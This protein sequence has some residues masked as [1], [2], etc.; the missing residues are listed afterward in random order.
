MWEKKSP[1]QRISNVLKDD[2]KQQETSN[3][4][5]QHTLDI[6]KVSVPCFVDDQNTT[7]YV[8][9]IE[10]GTS[11]RHLHRS[12]LDFQHLHTMLKEKT[13]SK[14]V[15]EFLLPPAHQ[16]GFGDQIKK[17]RRQ[18][19]DYFCQMLVKIQPMPVVISDFFEFSG[20][21]HF[22]F[23]RPTSFLKVS[24][25][26]YVDDNNSN[27]FYVIQVDVDGERASEVR[28][29]FSDF[30]QLYSTLKENPQHQ[31]VRD[32]Q[33]PDANAL[34]FLNGERVKKERLQSFHHLC[35]IW[36]AIEPLPTILA[37]FF[38]LNPHF[39]S[40]LTKLADEQPQP[41]SVGLPEW[42]W[43]NENENWIPYKEAEQYLIEEAFQANV[44]KLTL[45]CDHN[46]QRYCVNTKESTQTNVTSGATK[47]I[48]RVFQTRRNENIEWRWQREDGQWLPYLPVE[49]KI[50]EEA[51]QT[52]A[53]IEFT[54][55]ENGQ[56]YSIDTRKLI[57]K[58]LS[59]ETETTVQRALKEQVVTP[60]PFP[61]PSKSENSL[62]LE[63][64]QHWTQSDKASPFTLVSLESSS[65]EYM[66]VSQQFAQT[67]SS[68]VYTITSIARVQNLNL[69]NEYQL[70]RSTLENELGQIDI[71]EQKL[72][73]GTAHDA[74]DNICKDGFDWRVC[75][76]NGT[77]YGQG[78]YF[79]MNSSYSSSY[80]RENSSREC[81]MFLASVLL[82]R[83]SQGSHS[84]VKA[85]DGFHSVVNNVSYP[86]I[87]VV[88]LIK[89][90]YPEYL[91]SF[92]KV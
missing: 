73:H 31:A 7:L 46:S 86:T 81:K 92:R 11:T 88:F 82:G 2:Q 78:S 42:Q 15:H 55:L 19:I 45:Q 54:S 60:V 13:Q 72:F 65:K 51:Y 25:P 50:I 9:K 40:V 37:D 44:E 18:K 33:F 1:E 43:C 35:Q 62:A 27:T 22:A 68:A 29:N 53:Q 64:P 8:V 6:L 79:A 32:F 3:N 89:Q 67:C 41:E 61:K 85:P 87:F 4:T 48:Q 77:V 20:S 30:E 24:I 56:T 76:K 57:Q 21:E 58:N 63:M 17:Q 59:S 26:Y 71:N 47:K 10:I 52:K 23:T 70:Y 12:F 66:E 5:A 83:Y 49:Q 38:S 39:I 28:R 14:E 16:F 36:A 74:V 91:I 90:A 75:G 80:A 34:G 69:Y 84:L